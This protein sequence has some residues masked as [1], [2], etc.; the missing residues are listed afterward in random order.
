LDE[1]APS[2]DVSARDSIGTVHLTSNN[3]VLSTTGVVGNGRAFVSASSE[4]LSAAVHPFAF[5]DTSWSYA[6]WHK[7]TTKTAVQ[8]LASVWNASGNNRCWALLYDNT[9]DRLLLHGSDAGASIAGT[10][11]ANTF[12]SPP[13]GTWFFVACG[14]DAD[15]DEIWISVNGGAANET[16]LA[17]GLYAASTA[18]F[19]IGSSASPGSF[20]N[21]AADEVG[22]WT[23][24]LT[25]G[26]IT[27]L[28]N[29]PGM[30]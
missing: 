6:G 15:A 19:H 3:T 29:A 2:G 28:Y 11:T 4:H 12:G 7:L 20:A 10:A 18:T 9:S 14:Y 5:G 26:E 24:R 23:R 17:G 22:I 16:S 1:A 13:T 8:F 30:P 27:A 25:S 21:G